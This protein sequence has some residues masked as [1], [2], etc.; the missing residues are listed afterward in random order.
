MGPCIREVCPGFQLPQHYGLIEVFRPQDYK[1][2]FNL[3]HSQARNVV[4]RVFGVVKRRFALMT[5]APEYD[6]HT[7]SKITLALCVLHNFIRVHDPQDLSG[8]KK[9][10]VEAELNRRAPRRGPEEYGHYVSPEESSRASNRRDQ[11]AKAM[12]EQYQSYL[13]LNPR[14][15]S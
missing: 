12:W 7:Q 10:E 3:R 4:E 15:T 13:A 6:L 9:E 5:A 11:I 8:E 2:L 1:E 14:G